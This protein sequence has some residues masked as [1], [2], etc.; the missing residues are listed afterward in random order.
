[1]CCAAAGDDNEGG[2]ALNGIVKALAAARKPAVCGDKARL[3]LM[4]F[5]FLLKGM[6]SREIYVPWGG[7]L[8]RM[9]PRL[10]IYEWARF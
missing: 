2:Y 10:L 3:T 1:M 6:C 9:I 5:F 7:F 4:D 8:A